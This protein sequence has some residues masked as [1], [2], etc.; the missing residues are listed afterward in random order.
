[1]ETLRQHAEAPAS[2]LKGADRDGLRHRAAEPKI[3]AEFC[4]DTARTDKDAVR[5]GDGEV[6]IGIEGGLSLSTRFRLLVKSDAGGRG[7]CRVDMLGA[8]ERLWGDGTSVRKCG[9]E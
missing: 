4:I 9:V 7:L 1:I 6:D 8:S 2:H 3:A 5:R